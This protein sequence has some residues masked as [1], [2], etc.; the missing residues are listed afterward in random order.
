[1]ILK[2]IQTSEDYVR[3]SFKD[4]FNENKDIE[5]RV[6]R[7]V[8]Y[9]DQLLKEYKDSKPQSIENAHYHDDNYEMISIYLAF[10]FPNIYTPYNFNNF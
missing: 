7:F 5:G 3:Y 9:C 8:F 4:L 6:D 10:H 2:F 1:M